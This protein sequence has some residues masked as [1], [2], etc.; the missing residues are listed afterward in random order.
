LVKPVLEV[1]MPKA[2]QRVN[3]RRR[4]HAHEPAG[5]QSTSK[6]PLARRMLVLHS[7]LLAWYAR[8]RRDLPWRRTADPYAV[9]VSEIMLQ[10]TRV[11]TVIPHYERF[12]AAFPTVHA[13]AEAPI[14]DVLSRWS[15]LGYY[16]RARMLHEGAREIAGP[17][18]GV[19]PDTPEELLA[20]KGIGQYT[21]GAIASIAF[22]RPAALVD[23]NVVRVFARIFAIGEDVRGG[24]GLA[25]VWSIARALV[26][27]EDAGSWNQALMELGAT[28]CTPRQ[29]RCLLC[30]A[31][32]VCEARALGKENDLP[33]LSRKAA[34][35]PVRR[36]ALVATG[37]GGRVLLGKRRPAGLYGG[38]WEPP[39]LDRVRETPAESVARFESLLGL[40]LG[41]VAKAGDVTHVL[42]HRRLRIEVL[43]GPLRTTRIVKAGSGS[44]EYEAF[45][46]VDAASLEARGVATLARKILACASA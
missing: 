25:R 40:R 19:F 22:G 44:V 39:L 4:K 21:A 24:A 16:R 10:Q 18:A 32:A 42:S 3:R 41:P 34:P 33:V 29:P 13:L 11:E 20:I 9:W 12:L 15:G 37:P 26:P 7:A 23:G 43:A 36:L 5:T 27:E 17:R 14:D 30:P 35:K 31:R 2:S 28:L 1:A 8:E 6:E 45:E 46:L 38:L